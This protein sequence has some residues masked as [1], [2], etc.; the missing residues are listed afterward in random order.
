MNPG[1]Y[2]FVKDSGR[3]YIDLPE[4]VGSRAD[5]EMVM[6]ADTML[7]AISGG[8]DEVHLTMCDVP[9]V[10]EDTE[11]IETQAFPLVKIRDTPEYGG[12]MYHLKEWYGEEYNTEMWLCDVVK[13]VF[14]RMPEIIYI[15]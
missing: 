7:D 2:K 6:G 4:Y 9:F 5:L 8:K 11:P 13:F 14:G 10:L 15:A 12:A 1:V 3:W